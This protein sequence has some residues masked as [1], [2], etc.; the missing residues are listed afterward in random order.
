ML[1]PWF[2]SFR[3][4]DRAALRK[5]E[6][7]RRFQV[8]S[9][10]GRQMLST[11]T[12]TSNADSGTNSLRWAITQSD[13]TPSTATSPNVINFNLG[14]TG[15]MASQRTISVLSQLPAITQPVTLNATTEAGYN[16][17]PI[18]GLDGTQASSSAIGLDIQSNHVTVEGLDVT[19]FNSGGIL[20]D[21]GAYKNLAFVDTLSN[22]WVGL[23]L[24]ANVAGNGTFGVELR[25]GAFSNTLTNDVVA[26]NQYN[27]IV[28]TGASSN[29]V[30]Q[31]SFIGTD[32]TGV[33]VVDDP[34]N[35]LGN[36]VRG[37]GGSGVVINGGSSDNLIGGTTTATLD[38]INNNES[39]GVYITDSSTN[40]NQVEGDVIDRNVGPGVAIVNAA[41]YTT[42]SGDHI[43]TDAGGTLRTDG[44]NNF[45]GNGTDGVLIDGGAS[46]NTVGGTTAAARNLI[47]N[48]AQ[49]GVYLSDSG[50]SDN[51]VEGNY[52]GTN[53]AGTGAL[54]NG[55]N[56]LDIVSGASYNTVGG[57]TSGAGNLISGNAYNGVV[58]AFSGASAN[59]VEGN[60]IGTNAAGTGALANGADGVIIQ[61]GAT[62]NTLGGTTAGARNVISGNSSG[63]GVV[64]TDPGTSSNLVEG[65]YVGT[66]TAGTA[67]LGN[68]YGVQVVNGATGNTIGGTTSGARNVVSAN[69]WDG[70]QLLGSGTS[71]NI[72]EGNYLGL[73]AAG[74]AGL[75]N[76]GSGIAIAQR[77]SSNTIG[78]GSAVDGNA[79]SGNQGDG[80]YISDSGTTGNTVQFNDIGTDPTGFYAVPNALNGVI[81]QSGATYSDI[82][83]DVISGNLQAGVQ[84]NAASNN[85]I[86]SCLIGVNAAQTATVPVAGYGYSDSIGVLLVNGAYAT[87]VGYN[88]I[89][90]N[91][92][93]V[94]VSGSATN[95]G[96]VWDHIGTN[97]AGTLNLGNTEFGV[98]LNSTSGNEVGY[99]TIDDSG[100]YGIYGYYSDQNS[101]V[102][103]AYAGNTYGNTYFY[104]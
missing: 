7:R 31:G 94:E 75:G 71:G 59:L 22:D 55:Y 99:D 18:I 51:L 37:G 72:L 86:T 10:E 32:N 16:G 23:N 62:S 56:G 65:N 77:A 42:V 13:N 30:V 27:G 8:E 90:G 47:A 45:L 48:S 49:W 102:S 85:Y 82:Y 19:D 58:I 101:I 28:I 92:I 68:H 44:N 104:G 29:N 50:T 20:V 52:I 11:F 63:T 2:R 6:R 96:V 95:N 34:G 4:N 84:V 46:Y 12:V 53:A 40:S 24:A 64:I 60:L 38:Y 91:Q 88:V 73:N 76:T 26:G 57:T 103:D 67:G 79:I 83:N 21:G 74:T 100:S 69:L 54:P 66:N 93:G 33:D 98:Y 89:G 87:S 41:A 17:L 9:L 14:G 80:V 3:K 78:G 5:Q 97:S 25:D 61:G 1:T 70:V 35:S 39:Y 36:G 15:L 43:G 81:I